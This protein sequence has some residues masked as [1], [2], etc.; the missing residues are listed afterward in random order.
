MILVDNTGQALL[1]DQL[2]SFVMAAR[3]GN[4]STQ[5]THIKNLR[6]HQI[7]I[8]KQKYCNFINLFFDEFS[9]FDGRSVNQLSAFGRCC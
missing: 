7:C 1:A 5:N 9:P 6:N 4:L 2:G 3:F 8:K